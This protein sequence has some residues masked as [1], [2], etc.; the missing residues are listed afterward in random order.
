MYKVVCMN[1]QF[2][3]FAVV[4][5]YKDT[6]NSELAKAEHLPLGNV[7]GWVPGLM[8]TTFLSTD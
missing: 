2:S 7:Q 5:V 6:S 1:S 8:V 3:L 4:I